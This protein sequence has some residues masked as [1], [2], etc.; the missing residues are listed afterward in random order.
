MIALA[1]VCPDYLKEA[2]ITKFAPAPNASAVHSRKRKARVRIA[3]PFWADR[4][5]IKAFYLRAQ[6]YTAKFGRRYVVDHIVPLQHPLVCGLHVPANM[7][8]I[9]LR[10]NAV[11]NNRFDPATAPHVIDARLKMS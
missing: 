6:A 3:T 5:R 7:R 10:T 8:I 2:P 11:K 4:R 9:L 1:P